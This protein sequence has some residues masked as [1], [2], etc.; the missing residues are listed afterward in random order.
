MP[1]AERPGSP[2]ACA[3]LLHACERDRHSVRVRGGGTKDH[4][5]TRRETDVTLETA[6]L[7]GIV[8]H[9]P[10]DLTVTVR[11]GMRFAAL[12]AA[13]ATHGQFLPLDPPHTRR[14]A[15]VGGII[16][17]NSSGFGRYRFGAVRDLLLGVR[18]ALPDGTVARAGGRVVKN[19]AGYDLNKLFTGSLGT[20]GVIVEATFK[21]LPI[22]PATRAAAAVFASSADAFA[23]ADALV[24]TSL[25]PTALVVE[26][27]DRRW[28]LVVA[29][30]GERAPVDRAMDEL[31]RVAAAKGAAVEAIAD[32]EA[33]LGPLRELVDLSPTGVIIR[34][35][36]PLSAQAAY[37]EAAARGER[38]AHIV[39]DAASAI[40]HVHLME[41]ADAVAAETIVAT[42]RV[43]GGSARIE[44][45]AIAGLATF[46]GP[47]PSGAFLMRRLKDA[48]DPHGIL[49]PARGALG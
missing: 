23:A 15:T 27:A 6:G 32:P 12:Q 9:V 19:V 46:S 18:A 44:R 34:A 49:E 39:A 24:R 11:G 21:I 36:L 14:G 8:D 10:E 37:A 1:R 38:T 31:A 13:L 33:T 17:A 41:G 25:R 43:L 48:F 28:R 30:A 45:G 4:L 26:H 29:A 7:D 47:E 2:E 16:A 42:A 20:L 35:A 22:P 5:G 40:V 3:E